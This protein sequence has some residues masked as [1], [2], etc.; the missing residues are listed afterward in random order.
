M[1]ADLAFLNA[2]VRTMNPRQP[3]AQAVAVSKNKILK[4]GSN[5]EIKQLIDKHTK[6][7]DLKGK[8]VVP[9]LIDTHIHLADFGRC[10]MWLDVSST[11]SIVELQEKLSE[12]AKETGVE[13]WIVGRGWN[14]N[15]FKEKRLLEI[16]DLDAAAPNNPV[17]L[18]HDSAMICAVNSKALAKAGV[19][20]KTIV[21]SGG[22]IDYDVKGELTGIFRDSATNLVWQAVPEPS[23]EELTKATAVACHEIVKSGLT[24]VHWILISE[25]EVTLVKKL[26][27]EGRLPL[28]VNVI[29]PEAFWEQIKNFQSNDLSMLR[30]GGVIIFAD[31]YLDSKTASL[32][33]PYD[34]E[35]SNYGKLLCTQQQLDL[36]VNTVLA[37]GYQPIVHAMG[38]KAV[39]A[40]LNAIEKAPKKGK[41]PFRIEQAAV[42]NQELLE[43]LKVNDVVVTVQPK[44]ITT[45]FAVWSA[46]QHLGEQRAKWLHPLKTLLNAGVRIAGG[47]DCPMEP[48]SPLLGMHELVVRPSFSEQRL[49]PQEALRMYTLDA[50]YVSGEENHKGSIEEGKLADLTVLASDPLTVKPEEIK[51]IAVSMVV[52]NGK[53]LKD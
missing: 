13:N 38:D 36:L 12:K 41:V 35:P 49:S 18:Y 32:F 1:S 10:L 33:E 5:Q 21:P 3:T 50:A 14:E 44:V 22:S 30:V 11:E 8:T 9:G 24:S 28:R 40:A 43:R 27:A 51:D 31:G 20:K 47:S 48:L 46:T 52:V 25:T 17:I 39:D 16:A 29:V 4:V 53:I 42:L 26:H 7:I 23:L 37:A 2:N 45:E 34:D 15:R 19:S 6:T